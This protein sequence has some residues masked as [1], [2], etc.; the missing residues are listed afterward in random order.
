MQKPLLCKSPETGWVLQENGLLT[1]FR[2][3]L[4][5]V[6]MALLDRSV[7]AAAGTALLI[8][9]CSPGAGI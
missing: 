1:A 6:L 7:L 4:V 3:S 2:E 8:L 9:H 5:L